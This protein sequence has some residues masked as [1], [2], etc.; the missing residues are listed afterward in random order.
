M[1]IKILE[2]FGLGY[3]IL[4]DCLRLY[5]DIILGRSQL[6]LKVL[7]D[8]LYESGLSIFI[9]ISLVAAV[10]GLII[11]IETQNILDKVN[12]PEMLLG[13]I[14]LSIIKQFAPLLVGLF[15]AGRSGI[16]L[17]VR[18]GSMVL[19]RE[20]D[21]L[22]VSGVDPIRYTVGPM[23]LAMLLMSFTLA[24]WTNL[25]VLGVASLWLASEAGIPW[26]LFWETLRDVLHVSDLLRSVI[27]PLI[28]ALLISLI[29]AVNGYRVGR[30]V[31][32]VSQAATRTMIVAIMAIQIVN[33]I[34][35]LLFGA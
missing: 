2:N 32:A 30:Q 26:S 15:V 3:F 28:F 19:N 18:I 14:G 17:T 8:D 12:I 13:A 16:G 29:A 35:I 33:L 6:D 10:V 9:G 22:I 21:G 23:L 27:K 4:L 24:V 11:G 20:M 25:V 5:R 7:V 31:E 34:F 1:S